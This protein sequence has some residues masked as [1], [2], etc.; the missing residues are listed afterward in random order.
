MSAW[1]KLLF[2]CSLRKFTTVRAVGY[3]TATTSVQTGIR[4]CLEAEDIS[5]RASRT[6]LKDGGANQTAD[7]HDQ[8]QNQVHRLQQYTH[9]LSLRTEQS[10][11][12]A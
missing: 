5:G 3:A 7:E 6:L 4:P 1:A 9:H 11:T 2:E 10:R 8:H 12:A